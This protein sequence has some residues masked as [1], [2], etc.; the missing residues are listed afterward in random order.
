MICN[1]CNYEFSIDEDN[2]PTFGFVC[3]CDCVLCD[4]CI[5]EIIDSEDELS[6]PDCGTNYERS[7]EDGWKK[8]E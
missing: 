4:N 8:K 6:C 5:S 7:V 1:K 2:E 3:D